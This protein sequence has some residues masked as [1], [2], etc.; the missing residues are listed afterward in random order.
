LN[1]NNFWYNYSWY[2]WPSSDYSS[3]HLTQHMLL[4]YLGK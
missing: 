1:F 4:H 3:F 2:N